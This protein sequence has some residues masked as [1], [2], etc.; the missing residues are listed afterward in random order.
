MI[1]VERRGIEEGR[2]MEAVMGTRWD[3]TSRASGS[4][5][6]C[7]CRWRACMMVLAVVGIRA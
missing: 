4:R 5:G 6:R 1:F 7:S 3:R 2:A